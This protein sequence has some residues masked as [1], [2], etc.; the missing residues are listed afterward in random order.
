MHHIVWPQ[1]HTPGF[2][3]NYASNDVI[4]AGL[5][6]IFD[7]G[8]GPCWRRAAVSFSAPSAFRSR[9]AGAPD[10]SFQPR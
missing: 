9:H 4:V 1:G 10:R 5:S 2:A 6:A 8:A 3:D 7:G